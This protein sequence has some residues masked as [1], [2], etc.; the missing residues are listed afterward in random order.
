MPIAIII[1]LNGIDDLFLDLVCLYDWA[2]RRLSKDRTHSLTEKDFRQPP[3]NRLAI[4]IPCWHEHGV[5]GAMVE[6]NVAAINYRNYDFFIGAYPNDEP[7]IEAVRK[8]EVRFK[9]VHLAVCPHDGPTSKADCLNWIYQRMLLFEEDHDTR[10]ELVITHDAEDLIHPDSLLRF[11]YYGARYDFVQIP[12]FALRTP[13][14]MIA[15]G[16]YCDEFTESQVRDMRAR[17]IMG[18]FIPSSGVGTGYSRTAL[19]KLADTEHNR[20][21]EPACLTEDYEN[22]MRLHRLGCSQIFVSPMKGYDGLL[23]T[24]E[25]FPTKTRAAIRQRTR[26]IMGIA[27][28][29]WERHGWSGTPAQRYW[30]W[31]DRKGLI[32]NPVSLLA[33]LVFLYLGVTWIVG[34]LLRVPWGVTPYH[35]PPWLLYPS[36]VLLVF[37]VGWRTIAVARFYGWPFALGVPVRI[38]WANVINA[39][40]TVLAVFRYTRARLRHEPLVW[41]K[42]EHAYPSRTALVQHK[43]KLGE[44]LVGS[45]YVE[46]SDVDLALANCPVGVRLG[47]YLVA[48]GK[49]SEEDLYEALSLQQCLPSGN[50]RAS[51][52]SNK[53]ARSLPRQLI[54]DSKVLPY[55]IAEGSMFLASPEIPTDALAETLRGFTRMA[56]RFQLVTP[57]NFK[58]LTTALL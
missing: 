16:V 15:H 31:R 12:V 28:Q 13:F 56:L 24:R 30:F 54:Q 7:T 11:N 2:R 3:L 46:E 37:H 20:I 55:R 10:F 41:V 50:L 42:T 47:E 51:D 14:K 26:W 1:L 39:C 57:T 53:V 22:G 6:H 18:S 27:L 48:A 17:A 25:L 34:K 44:I 40:A 8:L 9:N 29:T 19:E 32:G 23:A 35:L 21:F 43:R 36:L 33:N 4:Y 52:I 49:L 45:G 58:E 5:I 38:V